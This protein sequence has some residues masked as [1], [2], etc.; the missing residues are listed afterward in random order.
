MPA[1]AFI[2][3]LNTVFPVVAVEPNDAGQLARPDFFG[4][5][6]AVAPGIFMTAA[7]VASAAQEHGE[8]AI[9]GPVP[10]QSMMGGARVTA[11][12]TI[13]DRDIALLFCDAPGV[14]LLNSWLTTR[15]QV[16]TELRS[17]GYP[18]AV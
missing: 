11:V 16:L 17:F 14:T 7:H 10:E 6:F 1:P 3:V 4:T 8:L 5:A 18:H 12:E 13:P 2:D 9:G 15:L